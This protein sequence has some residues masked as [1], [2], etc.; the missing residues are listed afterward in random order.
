MTD[1]TPRS[2]EQLCT[3]DELT[4]LV[5]AALAVDY[6]GSP[7]ARVRDVPDRRAIRWYVTRGLVD[8]PVASRGRIALYSRRHLLQLVAIKRLQAQGRSLADIQAQLTGATN[9]VLAEVARVPVEPPETAAAAAAATTSPP[10]SRD[11]FWARHAEAAITDF[12]SVRPAP[13]V[14]VAEP[15]APWNDGELP[16]DAAARPGEPPEATSPEA[17][18]LQGIRL[19]P[20]VTLLIEDGGGPPPDPVAVQ[21]AARPLLDLLAAGGHL[22]EKGCTS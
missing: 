2:T 15:P 9:E 14:W 21:A 16:N 5:E 20:G 8:R 1:A 17:V 19:A 13:P 22:T 4:G 6:P 11:R 7:T 3:L 12:T 10:P 18:A